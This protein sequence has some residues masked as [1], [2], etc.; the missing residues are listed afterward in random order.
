[1]LGTEALELFA[2]LGEAGEHA[3]A[4]FV[5]GTIAMFTGDY[6]RAVGLFEQSL[7][8]RRGGATSTPPPGT[9][10][11]WAP[12]CSTWATWPGPG[13]CSRKAWRWRAGSTTSGPRPC[14]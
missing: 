2:E 9:S 14:R 6:R 4:L 7:A 3:E 1:M 12:P 13:P 10:A 5:L 8:E 11:G